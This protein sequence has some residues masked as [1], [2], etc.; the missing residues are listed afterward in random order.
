[1]YIHICLINILTKHVYYYFIDKF[2]SKQIKQ[3]Y[4]LSYCINPREWLEKHMGFDVD[5]MFFTT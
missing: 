1:M 5:F 4:Y 3:N 2:I